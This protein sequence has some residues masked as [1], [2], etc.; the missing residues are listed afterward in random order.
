MVRKET[1]I[2]AAILSCLRAMGIFA[3]RQNTGAVSE[4]KRFVR[5]AFPGI[6]D[7]LG[8][9]PGGKFLAIEV[10]S[11]RGKLT[12]R[13]KAFL[14]HVADNQGVAIVARCVDDVIKEVNNYRDT[15]R[16]SRRFD[17]G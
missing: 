11:D 15:A 13:Q 2:Q 4:G 8:V 12:P 6:S 17:C 5:F 7:I 9:L 14:Q 3:W 10:K 1:D 16:V